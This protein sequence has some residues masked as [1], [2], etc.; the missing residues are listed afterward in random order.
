MKRAK[1][2]IKIGGNLISLFFFYLLFRKTDFRAIVENLRYVQ[3]HSILIAGLLYAGFVVLR[4]FYQRNN[5]RYLKEGIDY[6]H[7]VTGVSL[8][9]FYNV[10]FPARIGEVIRAFYLS[11]REG[12]PKGTLLSYILIEKAIDFLFMLL[13]LAV[14]VILGFHNREVYRILTVSVGVVCVIAVVVFL[15]IRY[16]RRVVGLLKRVFPKRLHGNLDR[17][18]R[19][20]VEGLTC[21]R[22]PGQVLESM[23]LMAVGW[24]LVAAAFWFTSAGYA[25]LLG[26]PPYS[27]LFL[28]V[29]SALS[30]SIPSA[31]AGIGVVHYGQFLAIK[32]MTGEG[33][34]INMAASFT[35][36]LHFFT[37]MVYDLV[38]G[39]GF[40]V[41]GRIGRRET[42]R[43]REKIDAGRTGT[44]DLQDRK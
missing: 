19:S 6:L 9:L 37:G 39:G 30:L 44:S 3:L 40:I 31:P 26:L 28:M 20:L 16:N 42:L 7:S 11:E 15:Y 4:G 33:L 1:T 34:D 32:L 27:S 10:I 43:I 29:F 12:I 22:S 5:L 25:D 8:A 2:Y 18:D 21:F 38:I 17:L 36:V 41:A 23:T 24:G 35:L 14:I 13:L